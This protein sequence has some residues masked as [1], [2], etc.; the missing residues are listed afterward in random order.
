MLQES[1]TPE[2]WSCH[3]KAFYLTGLGILR[4]QK[5]YQ[6]SQT[7]SESP[8]PKSPQLNTFTN[9]NIDKLLEKKNGCGL[10]KSVR[11]FFSIPA[12]I[13][14][15]AASMLPVNWLHSGFL[16]FGSQGLATAR[17]TADTEA[18]WGHAPRQEHP[19]SCDS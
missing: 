7:N 16:A 10:V 6:V 15:Q 17:V 19:S 3:V 11:W 12:L 13:P 8:T 1:Q 4:Q 2:N 9:Y 14:S 18:P 5:L